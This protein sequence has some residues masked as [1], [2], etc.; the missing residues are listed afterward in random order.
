MEDAAIEK[1]RQRNIAGIIIALIFSCAVIIFF[2]IKSRH[3]LYW[4]RIRSFALGPLDTWP[5]KG[6]TNFNSYGAYLYSLAGILLVDFLVLRERSAIASLLKFRKSERT[7]L[8]VGTA[9]IF[10]LS[11]TIPTVLT[12]GATAF[13]PQYLTRWRLNFID[14]IPSIYVQIVI[15]LVALDFF[16]YWWHRAMHQSEVLWQFHAFH[17]SATT[18]T[19][20]TGNRIHPIETLMSVVLVSIPM[21]F[22]GAPTSSIFLFLF[23]RRL[24]DMAQHS[25]IPATFGSFGK[26]IIFSPVGHRIHHSDKPRHFDSNYGN[27]FSF[28]DHIFGTWY[29][30]DDINETIGIPNNDF[31]QNGIVSDLVSPFANAGKVIR[32]KARRRPLYPS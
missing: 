27:I 15:W 23:I 14:D 26:W 3:P 19:I 20:F 6:I 25:F 16:H 29:E 11:L 31:N 7:D 12:G 32:N 18:F 1:T 8:V 13:I 2:Y 17:H 24:F 4:P 22:V 10:G 21:L 9:S 30:G 28:W 5:R